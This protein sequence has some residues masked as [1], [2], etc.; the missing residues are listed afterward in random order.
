M[1]LRG[2]EMEVTIGQ[3]VTIHYDRTA[4]TE[5]TTVA[6]VTR[7]TGTQITLDNGE[8]Y[9]KSTGVQVGSRGVLRPKKITVED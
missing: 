7:V 6:R 9:L 2:V 8:R 5:K 1:R 4:S 3:T